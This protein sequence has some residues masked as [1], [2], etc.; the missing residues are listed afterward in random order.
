MGFS[1]FILL[2][3]GYSTEEC[4]DFFGHANGKVH[5]IVERLLDSVPDALAEPR[6]AERHTPA[7]LTT[8]TWPRLH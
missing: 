1:Y 6:P 5:S 8:R 7:C 4:R 3:N 2:T